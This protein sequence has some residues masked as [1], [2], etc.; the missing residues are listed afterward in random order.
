MAD[1]GMHLPPRTNLFS[2]NGLIGPKYEQVRQLLLKKV[3][4]GR[5]SVGKALPSESEL[6]EQFG[7]SRVTVRRALQC[8]VRDGIIRSEQGLGH[9]VRASE[10]NPP[11]GIIF[12]NAPHALV[13]TP[14]YRLMIP[15]I[16]HTL[17]DHGYA[18]QLYLVR[19]HPSEMR[20]DR[21]RLIAD[22]RKRVI[23]GLIAVAWPYSEKEEPQLRVHDEEL[24]NLIRSN[25]LP[26]IGSTGSGCT[27]AVMIDYASLARLGAEHFLDKGAEPIALIVGSDA[28]AEQPDA[29]RG[30][31]EAFERR[32]RAVAP[33]Y[34]VRIKEL[35]QLAGYAAMRHIAAL[36][37][38]PRAVVISDDIVARGAMTAILELGIDVPHSLELATLYIHEA[39]MFFPKPF[40]RLE[41]D[42]DRAG[43]LMTDQLIKALEHPDA[44]L[45]PVMLVPTVVVPEQ[46]DPNLPQDRAALLLVEPE[47]C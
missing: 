12:G 7:V 11:I 25:N 27:G 37:P 16:Q 40:V 20:S 35:S 42:T 47:T 4:S 34:I 19:S 22:I 45:A 26:L 28:V 2:K 46:N 9:I 18:N 41:M 3:R 15:K 8:L 6:L 10:I 38:P 1:T 39:D 14:T 31:R 17:A 13:E 21:A 24:L 30:F 44:V 23:H 32:G 5:F 29:V 43:Q 36:T 33:Q